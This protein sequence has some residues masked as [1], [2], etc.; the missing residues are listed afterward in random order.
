MTLT[1]VADTCCIWQTRRLA[2]KE[3]WV[4]AAFSATEALRQVR[5][6]A[7]DA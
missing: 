1:G 4:T 2:A 6:Y 3:R 5:K 7:G